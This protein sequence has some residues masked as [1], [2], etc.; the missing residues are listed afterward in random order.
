MVV[1]HQSNTYDSSA[2]G[3]FSAGN[4]QTETRDVI[5]LNNNVVL[6]TWF[7]G[8]IKT[9]VDFR[10]DVTKNKK[11]MWPTEINTVHHLFT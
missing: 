9:P 3:P 4:R 8:K 11:R 10:F 5:P 7:L 6:F 1:S 2:L